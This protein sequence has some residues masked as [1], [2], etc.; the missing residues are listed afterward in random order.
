M[1]TPKFANGFESLSEQAAAQ[2]GAWADLTEC[3]QIDY[4]VVKGSGTITGG[5]MRLLARRGD[6]YPP[7]VVVTLDATALQGVSN[8]GYQSSQL[9]PHGNQFAWEITTAIV[10]G[11]VT[12]S[13]NGQRSGS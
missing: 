11:T 1:A 3:S 10:G 12:A 7:M 5:A 2:V 13:L 6:G 8:V 4:G 9:K